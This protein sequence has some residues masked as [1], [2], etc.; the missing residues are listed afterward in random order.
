MRRNRRPRRGDLVCRRADP[1]HVGRVLAVIGERATL[2]WLETQ[3]LEFGVA[4]ADL[5][6][7]EAWKSPAPASAQ[8]TF[9]SWVNKNG[10]V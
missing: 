1:V 2:R 10:V 7:A 9:I 6:H 8:D 3:W 4:L 5:Q